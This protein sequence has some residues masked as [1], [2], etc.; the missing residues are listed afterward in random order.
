MFYCWHI[1]KKGIKQKRICRGCKYLAKV[2][3]DGQN[4]W[5]CTY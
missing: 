3:I 1:A 2:T 5:L 4:R